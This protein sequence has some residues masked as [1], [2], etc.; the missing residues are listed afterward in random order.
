MSLWVV[1]VKY[2]YPSWPAKFK[3][4]TW[5][6]SN[7][8]ITDFHITC[9]I[10]LCFQAETLALSLV[11][12]ILQDMDLLGNMDVF[13]TVVELQA[14]CQVSNSSAGMEITKKIYMSFGQVLKFF[15]CPK[16]FEHVQTKNNFFSLLFLKIT[17]YTDRYQNILADFVVKSCKFW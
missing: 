3:L 13:T 14:Y 11:S 12:C 2:F 1:I 9:L 7:K 4:R 8:K 16:S 10:D 6:V 5:F 17:V 15:T